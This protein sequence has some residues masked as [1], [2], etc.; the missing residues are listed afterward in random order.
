MRNW[1]NKGS[2]CSILQTLATIRIA[3]VVNAIN[4]LEKKI[5]SDVTRHTRI[6]HIS[7]VPPPPPPHPP[8]PDALVNMLKLDRLWLKNGKKF[9]GFAP[10]L[11]KALVLPKIK[12]K[13]Q[14]IACG[15][16]IFA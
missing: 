8:P 14:K 11:P 3:R 2:V 13:C 5:V 6:I 7:G 9:R 16:T 10:T 4:D 12:S 15:A 1:L